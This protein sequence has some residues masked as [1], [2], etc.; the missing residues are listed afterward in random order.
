[1]KPTPQNSISH[2]SRGDQRPPQ[3]QLGFPKVDYAY[4]TTFPQPAVAGGPASM[5][6]GVE[7]A[8]T[9]RSISRH[10]INDGST[11][12]Y[13]AEALFFAW[14]TLTA[15]WPLGLLVRQLST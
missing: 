5:T 13:L 6:K 2:S 3:D 11:R 8:R 15:A 14:I 7:E 1:M 12:E 9:F 10:F 4:H